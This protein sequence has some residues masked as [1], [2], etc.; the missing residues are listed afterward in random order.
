[1]AKQNT[2][3]S[4]YQLLISLAL[5]VAALVIVLIFGAG[6][7]V[8]H[9]NSDIICSRSFSDQGSCTS[10][11]WGPW[12]VSSQNTDQN[13]CQTTYQESRTYTGLKNT[14]VGTFSVSANLHTHCALSDAA[15]QNGNGTVV[16]Q[17]SACQIQETRARV[18][19]GTGSGTSCQMPA[20]SSDPN[21][22]GASHGT[23]TG[24]QTTESGGAVDESKTT[25]V[26]ATYQQYLDM[27][28]ARL[29]AGAITLSPALVRPGDVTHVTWNAGHVLSCAVTG[30]NGD[31][32]STVTGTETSAPI[33]AQTT[34]TLVC[35]TA[36]GTTITGSAVVNI[37]P[38]FQE[39]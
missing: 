30:T 3:M 15:F 13:S 29:A 4:I 22:S 21:A 2:T 35:P 38:T 8:A 17:Y 34:F 23:V 37:T 9:G 18:V 1:M 25:T 27:L 19:A 6:L 26:S 11:A 39:N 24:S 14:V 16:S 10:G 12:T 28:D 5:A 7:K 31:A 36:L 33:T 32:W 20:G